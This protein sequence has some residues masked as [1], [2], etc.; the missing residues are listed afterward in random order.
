MGT[1]VGRSKNPGE[2]SQRAARSA[3]SNPKFRVLL[4]AALYFGSDSQLSST[5]SAA[6]AYVD[7]GTCST[8]KRERDGNQ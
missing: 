5:T 4:L 2:S 1:Y 6:L 3:S 7:I 8:T